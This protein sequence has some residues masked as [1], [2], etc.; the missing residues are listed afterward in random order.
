[1]YMPNSV[2]INF[3]VKETGCSMIV[4]LGLFLFGVFCFSPVI[5]FI[6]V[7]IIGAPLVI[8]EIP[9]AFF[10]FLFR[11]ELGLQVRLSP[12]VVCCGIFLIFSIGLGFIYGAYSKV[13]I[14]SNARTYIVILFWISCFYGNRKVTFEHMVYLALGS[15]SGWGLI[16][17]KAFSSVVFDS[18]EGSGATSGAMLAMSLLMSV[19]YLYKRWKIFWAANFLSIG[20]C[21]FSGTR[22]AMLSWLWAFIMS[23]FIEFRIKKLCVAIILVSVFSSIIFLSWGSL[24]EWVK[25]YSPYMYVRIFQKTNALITSGTEAENDQ[26]RVERIRNLAT[27]DC[28]SKNLIPRGLVSKW[29]TREAGTGIFIDCPAYEVYH[30]FGFL[31]G[32]LL[33]GVVTTRILKHLQLFFRKKQR[34][35]AVFAIMGGHM[36]IMMFYEG[37]F[38]TFAPFSIFT[39]FAIANL[40][41]NR[42]VFY[43]MRNIRIDNTIGQMK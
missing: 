38:I 36:I 18:Q 30:T 10:F 28:L 6:F 39:A 37:G 35:S 40:F 25:G 2:P 9:M 3:S 42:E 29:T 34:S 27:V 5:S 1:M 41:S 8:S 4:R 20:T 14:L 24:G 33:L 17:F 32:F 7:K 13:A 16:S 15:M 22:R 11:R 12:L 31:G 19:S 21:F 43:S 23:V 26:G